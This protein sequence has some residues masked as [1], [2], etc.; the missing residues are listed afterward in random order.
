MKR[1]STYFY[2]FTLIFSAG[3]SIG[4]VR[5]KRLRGAESPISDIACKTNRLHTAVTTRGNGLASMADAAGLY[6]GG[7]YRSTWQHGIQP[8]SYDI[9][10]QKILFGYDLQIEHV[11]DNDTEA[12]TNHMRPTLYLH[13]LGDTKHSAKLLKALADVLPGDVITFNFHD[14]GVVIPKVRHSN[15]GQLPD[16][17]PALYTLKWAK[18]HLKLT[19]V[20]LF[21]YSRGGATVLN[22]IAVLNDKTGKYDKELA[23]IGIDAK[24]RTALLAMI[25]K[26]CI[27]LNCPLTNANVSAKYR[28]KTLGPKILKAL[29]RVGLYKLDG[30]QALESAQTFKDLKLTILLHFQYR[31]TIVSNKNEAE[32]YYRLSQHNPESTYIVLG[33]NG[34]HLHT[35][36][37]LAHTIHTFK[38]MYG[39][40][41]DPSYDTQYHATRS[42]LSDANVLLQPGDAAEQIIATYYARCNKKQESVKR[43]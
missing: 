22:M 5:I 16:I 8:T 27:T 9:N 20:D 28:F 30:I 29:A 18:D 39:S 2:L 25:Q 35:H 42:L 43:R 24:E 41:Y 4:I 15:L 40:S 3:T 12:Q 31:D 17:L 37:A 19:E 1:I 10:A 6:F 36:A 33:N 7:K 21:G 38:K 13:G 34:G 23:R 14:R 32:L 11:V 26:G